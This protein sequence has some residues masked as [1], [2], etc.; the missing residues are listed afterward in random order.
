MVLLEIYPDKAK[1]TAL[2]ASVGTKTYLIS[3]YPTF[4]FNTKLSLP[5]IY[6]NLVV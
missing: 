3:K 4:T 1:Q 6:Q 5:I 2:G